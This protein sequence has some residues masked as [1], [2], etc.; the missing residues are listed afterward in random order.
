MTVPGT[1]ELADT[2]LGHYRI[3]TLIGRGGMGEVYLARDTTLGRAVA[4]KVLP[5]HL[6]EEA[7]R[8]ARFVQEAR[9]ASALNH[10]HLVAIYEIGSATPE[11]AGVAASRPVHYIAMELVTGD[12]LRTLIDR[13]QLDTRRTLAICTE[14]AD[15]VA[16]AHAAG[17]IHRDL[18]PENLMVAEGGYT[19]VLDF[20]LA[21]LRP[22]TALSSQ[23]TT[24][25][26][27]SAP[28]M[29]LGTA[30]Y[31]SPE[32]AEGRT[33]D[34][35]SDIFSFGC[36]LY[37]AATGVRAFGG[38]TIDM[39]HAIVN[40][41]PDA[42]ATHAPSTPA[43]LQRIVRKCL[44]KNPDNRYQSMKEVAID[45]R[46]LRRQLDSSASGAVPV[47]A[48]RKRSRVPIVITAAL[49]L[50]A[51]IAG[52][53]ASR[54]SPSGP[55][56]PLRVERLAG[57]EASIDASISPDG[58]YVVYVESGGGLQ[59]L[60]LRQIDGIRAIELVPRAPVGYWGIAF[61]P[62][63]SAIFY[64]IKSA[65]DVGGTLYRIPLLGGEPE[66]ILE[67]IDSGVTFVPDGKQ[68]AYLRADYPSPG[69]S[70]LMM[71]LSCCADSQ[72]RDT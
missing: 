9:A 31:M 43:E 38:S 28:G 70:A 66:R 17:I 42:M 16:A 29:L 44:A 2:S 5:P 72:R 45:L 47:P 22:D 67:G 34:H 54:E 1:G 46:D 71:P 62:D 6:V 51:A 15:A 26:A 11:K 53:L 37:E 18:K 30:G 27:G 33:I 3:E 41:E 35:R 59:R 55:R 60:M 7:D 65:R 12:T 69:A 32:Q 24:I 10:P 64:A 20:G 68:L 25:A 36:V 21:K 50:T 8:L 4:L 23:H 39:L 49:L 13:R 40:R 63:T 52:W 61:T 57:I 56:L 58:R 14:A 19:K 48:A